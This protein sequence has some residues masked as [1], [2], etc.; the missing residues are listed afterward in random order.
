MIEIRFHGRAGQGAKTAAQTLAVAALKENQFVQA[1]PN[2][3]PAR[4]GAPVQAFVRLDTTSI[5]LHSQ[6]YQPDFVVVLEKSLVEVDNAFEGTKPETKVLVNAP[7]P[8]PKALS[9]D[10]SRIAQHFLGKNLP[11]LVMV[12]AL[13]K[14]MGNVIDLKTIEATIAEELEAKVGSQVVEKNIL[15]LRQGYQEIL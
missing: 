8:I 10:A 12:G 11:N 15:A 2:F 1:F 9:I 13:L 14:V 6:I 3:G 7:Q 4:R 5:Y